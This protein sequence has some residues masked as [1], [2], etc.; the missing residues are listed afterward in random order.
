MIIM[1]HRWGSASKAQVCMF[2][3]VLIFANGMSPIMSSIAGVLHIPKIE[4][5]LTAHV[6]A[7]RGVS[8]RWN[9]AAGR[10]QSGM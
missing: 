5:A 2:V 4:E 1:W 8:W 10:V 3:A 6:S 7:P 9:A